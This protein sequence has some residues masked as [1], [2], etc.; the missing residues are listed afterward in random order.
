M[1]DSMYF[2]RIH[3]CLLLSKSQD[4]VAHDHLARLGRELLASKKLQIQALSA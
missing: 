1:D 4:L 2:G 3:V